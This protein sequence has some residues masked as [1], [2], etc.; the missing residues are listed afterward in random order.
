MGEMNGD[1]TEIT[2]LMQRFSWIDYVVFVFM[3]AISAVV[4]VY[5]GFMKKQTTQSDYLL[6]G[7]NMKV[8]PVSMSLVAR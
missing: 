2:R 1:V 8:I 7:R 3:L 4:G 6:G 5:W